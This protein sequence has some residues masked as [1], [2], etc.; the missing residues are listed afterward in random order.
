MENIVNEDRSLADRIRE[1]RR[2][3][4]QKI[5]Q[6]NP[7]ASDIKFDSESLMSKVSQAKQL[8]D[9]VGA[10]NPRLPGLLNGLIQAAKRWVSRVL[11][12]HTRPQ[13]EFNNAVI[14][15]MDETNR[16]VVTMA[17]SSKI[18]QTRQNELLS[19]LE[20]LHRQLQRE[21]ETGM[22]EQGSRHSQEIIIGQEGL[23]RKME[24]NLQTA[25]LELIEQLKLQR[26]KND[27][28]LVRQSSEISKRWQG[29]LEEE[30]RVLR[31]RLARQAR[32]EAP[33]SEN[34]ERGFSIAPETTTAL[35]GDYYQLEHYFR[36][37]EEEIRQRQSFYIPYF[38]GRKNVLDIAC[39]RGEFLELMR[40]IG[41]NARGVDADSDMIGRCCEKGLDV[42]R[43]DVFDYLRTVPDGSLDGI[44]C[45]QFVEHLKPETYIKLIDE[46][47][48][49]LM[50]EGILAMETPN[51]ECLAI[52]SQTFY[53]DPTHVGPIPPAQLRFLFLE[54][55]FGNISMH[56]FSPAEARY[57]LIPQLAKGAMEPSQ[58]KSW[59]DAVSRFNE[60]FFGSMD[61]AVIGYRSASFLVSSGQG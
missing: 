36:G 12:W 40:E 14:A 45:S 38:R 58:L 17:E 8:A 30:V 42:V 9:L 47:A 24:E 50:P 29:Q 13:K 28:L 3:I 39:G 20:I 56:Y 59:N 10:V 60:T 16:H 19:S 34:L 21:L 2:Q 49:K 51:P 61:Y 18:L 43:S 35:R 53:L 11:V 41:M 27:G 33:N 32:V 54:A 23:L 31:Q 26:W 48:R 6:A 46:C 55:G 52:F 37:T 22:L 44:F 25:Q 7:N 4:E 1:S 5:H 57:P 15:W